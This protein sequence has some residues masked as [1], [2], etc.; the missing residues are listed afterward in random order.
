MNQA[1]WQRVKDTYRETGSD[2]GTETDT[3]MDMDINNDMDMDI[4][5]DMDTDME[6]AIFCSVSLRGYSSCCTM[7]ITKILTRFHGAISNSAVHF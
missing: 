6:F 5:T 3:D 1:Q 4:D 2:T 7:F